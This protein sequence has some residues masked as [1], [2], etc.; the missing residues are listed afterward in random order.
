MEYRTFLFTYNFDGAK[1]E[2]PIKAKTPE[3]ARARLNHA[4]YAEY[5]GELMASIPVSPSGILGTF[6]FLKNFFR[7]RR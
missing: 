5:T 7:S 4:L 3:E 2:L 1:W 6:S